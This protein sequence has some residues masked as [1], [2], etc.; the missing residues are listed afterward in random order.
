MKPFN[1]FQLQSN[2]DTFYCNFLKL[3]DKTSIPKGV[4]L[5]KYLLMPYNLTTAIFIQSSLSMLNMLSIVINTAGEFS[6][7]LSEPCESETNLSVTKHASF[8]VKF[9]YSDLYS[10]TAIFNLPHDMH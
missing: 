2:Y 4:R 9:I 10:L 8:I 3:V 7:P 6:L 5:T 1:S